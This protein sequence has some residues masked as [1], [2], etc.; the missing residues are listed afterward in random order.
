MYDVASQQH[1]TV[2]YVKNLETTSTGECIVVY[3]IAAMANF[4][5]C[6]CFRYQQR[7]LVTVLL[8]AVIDPVNSQQ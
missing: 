4:L 7:L 8:Y 3:F 5:L 6:S 1:T 2:S